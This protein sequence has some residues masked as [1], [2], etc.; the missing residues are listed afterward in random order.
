M[1]LFDCYLMVDW[2]AASIPKTGRTASGGRYRGGPA[3]CVEKSGHALRRHGR[4]SSASWRA[5][6]PTAAGAGRFRLSFRPSARRCNVI[7]GSRRWKAS[8]RSSR[9]HQGRTEQRQQ[10]ISAA[11]NLNS[12]FEGP[13][14]FW[15]HPNSDATAALFPTSR[16]LD[17]YP[18]R[19]AARGGPI[20]DPQDRLAASGAG[21]VGGQTLVGIPFLKSCRVTSS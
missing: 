19:P 9:L 1:P 10:P 16:P 7:A 15:G 18:P 21:S 12:S 11:S 6:R 5:P 2:S 8:G 20:R 4:T 17:R 14:P 13:G 3:E